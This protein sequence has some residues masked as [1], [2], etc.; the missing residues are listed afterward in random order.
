MA[1][2]AV[3]FLLPAELAVAYALEDDTTTG[4]VAMVVLYMIGYPWVAAALLTVLDNRARRLAEPYGR[5]VDRL[6]GLVLANIAA[7]VGILI[8]LALL[9]VPGLLLAA[10]WSAVGPLIVLD[11]EGP[12]KAFETSNA[13]VR[14]RTWPV[15]GTLVVLF[16]AISVVAAPGVIVA[17]LHGSA[18]A[19]GL[20][21]AFADMV[22]LLPGTALTYAI[23]RRSRTT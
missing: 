5:S 10:R 3:L 6:P 9:I 20:G 19:R 17:E 1:L 7:S 23:Y 16:L 11:R 12:F 22:I 14:G 18:W 15:V 2:T 13:L 4:A 8:G 21:E